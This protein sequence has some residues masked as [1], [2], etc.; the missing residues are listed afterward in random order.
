MRLNIFQARLYFFTIFALFLVLFASPNLGAAGPSHGIAMYGTPELPPDFV[1]LPYANPDAPKG[2]QLTTGNV[3]SFNS[4]NPFAPKGDVP[5]QLRFLTHESLMGR[6]WDEPFSLYGLLAESIE[7]GPNRQWVEFN[8][9]GDARFS[10]GSRV[11][12][13]DV[14]WSYEA[15]GT[16]GHLRYRSFWN[17][18]TKIEQTGPRKIKLSFEDADRELA[19]IAGLRPILKKAQWQGKSLAD[20]ELAD[21]PIGSAPYRVTDYEPGRF[22]MLERNPD[23]W[24]ADLPLRRGTNNFDAI[25]IEFF[26]DEAV[27]KEAFKAQTLSFVRERNAEAWATQYDFPAVRDGKI[28][29]SEVPH[30]KPSGMTGFVFNTRRAPLDDW[31]VREALM[32][33][34]NFEF[35][36]E[37]LTGGRQP[38][39]TSY[40][41]GSELGLRPGPA[42]G[43]V[44]ALLEPF[45]ND[46]L[47]GALEGYTLP[48]GD[49]TQR[50][51]KNIRA[52]ARLLEE[53]GW[54]VV[55]GVLQN[56]D[57]EA[58]ELEAVLRNDGLLQQASAYMSIYTRALERLGISLTV[59]T[60]DA[61]QYSERERAFDFDLTFYRRSFSLSPGNEQ[62]LYW[63]AEFADQPGSRNLMGMRSPAAEAMIDAMLASTTREDFTAAVR[64]L[65]RVLISG[66]Y[67]IPIHTYAVGRIAH[68]SDL[69]YPSDRLPLY[70]DGV[71]FLPEVWWSGAEQ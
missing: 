26:G 8:L 56:A 70:G 33:A 30:Q 25:R 23:Y 61:A 37:A 50:N 28:T 15:L 14:I 47:P 2:G 13:E 40:F 18:I 6:S 21:I 60:V 32:L 43:R 36:N 58:L 62:Y 38:R 31:R 9:R 1:S 39:I 52:A 24:G 53:A 11:T 17:K 27:L 10:D 34:F 42:E 68:L 4:L 29:L 65:D 57:G 51:R 22:V 41:S 46:L 5:W 12:V 49:G 67:V 3:G 20:A 69:Q 44:R 48:Q 16:E 54:Q 64:A 7:T 71:G 59:Q 55:D 63:G 19:L 35:M 66:R 45:G